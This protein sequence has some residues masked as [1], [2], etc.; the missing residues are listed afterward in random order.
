MKKVLVILIMGLFVLA[1]Q[2]QSLTP[3]GNGLLNDVL[4]VEPV[5][6][7]LYAISYDN[8]EGDYHLHYFDLIEWTTLGA[9]PALPK[10][11]KNPEG[12]FHL[13]DLQYFKGELYLCGSYDLNAGN[14][15]N[16][17]ALKYDGNQWVDISNSMIQN[18]LQLTKYL[19]YND[20][21]I[22]VG[23][24]PSAQPVNLLSFS[25]GNWSPLGDFCTYDF[26]GDMIK[27][28][29]I[30]KNQIFASGILSKPG[31]SGKR[32]LMSFDGNKWKFN[33]NPPFLHKNSYFA[34]HKNFL[35]LTGTPNAPTISDYDYFKK[36][37]GIGT[38]WEDYSTGLNGIVVDEVKSL[39]SDGKVLWAT[40]TF[41]IK[42]TTDTFYL[43]Y[44]KDDRWYRAKTSMNASQSLGVWNQKAVIHGNFNLHGVR[45]IGN[46]GEGFAFVKGSVFEDTDGNCFQDK[47]EMGTRPHTLILNPGG[48]LISTNRNGEFSFPVMKGDYSLE[49]VEGPFWTSTC[50]KKVLF[51]ADEYI[52]LSQIYF[53]MKKVAGQVDVK[54]HLHD[55]K[56]QRVKPGK[57]EHFV[58][59]VRNRGTQDI[60][61]F[62]VQLRIHPKEALA[63]FSIQP[64]SYI[65]GIATWDIASL[66]EQEIQY[67]EIDINILNDEENFSI[68]YEV[69]LPNGYKDVVS[70]NDRD[71]ISYGRYS[72]EKDLEKTSNQPEMLPKTISELGYD[73]YIRNTTGAVL[74]KMLVVDTLDEDIRLRHVAVESYPFADDAQ[75]ENYLLPSG[76][77][78][79]VLKWVYTNANLPD[80]S[81]NSTGSVAHIKYDLQI[82]ENSLEEHA[83]VCN[84]AQLFIENFEPQVTNEVC[85]Q[86]SASVPR[87]NAKTLRIYPNPSTGTVTVDNVLDDDKQLKVMSM[88]GRVLRVLEAPAFE[89]TSFDLNSLSKGVYFISTEGYRAYKLILQ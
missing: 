66:R 56:G 39:A 9:L 77:Y 79:R 78:Q 64:S 4:L 38:S 42:N 49:L 1:A 17:I 84:Q 72:E 65:N 62:Q 21:I 74:N 87:V 15:Q 28:A 53:G 67:I 89:E 41:I 46:I 68:G 12:E 81:V 50:G 52:N 25:K 30:W 3:I 24:F 51:S 32:Y 20:Q 13:R 45:S 60:G 82:V 29:Y 19:I 14:Q 33:I 57:K 44:N 16:N 70:E 26:G 73:I 2:A 59:E 36:F 5:N 6:E 86:M 11:G 80:S 58:L 85:S 8:K 47:N 88:D 48:H 63:N 7:D 76:R 34:V 22:L 31:T 18:S 75:M 35:I 55:F 71:S 37:S 69:M 61:A 40:G 23:I 43:L 27:D 10:D 54:V 83:V